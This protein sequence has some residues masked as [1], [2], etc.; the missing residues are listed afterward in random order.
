MVSLPK[1]LCGG[2]S[3]PL[4]RL[5]TEHPGTL[6]LHPGFLESRVSIG[7]AGVPNEGE[8][9]ERAGAAQGA[10]ASKRTS[11]R[12][13][14][15]GRSW[16]PNTLPSPPA[17]RSQVQGTPRKNHRLGPQR[18]KDREKDILSLVRG[19]AGQERRR[20]APTPRKGLRCAPSEGGPLLDQ[21]LGSFQPPTWKGIRE[22]PAPTSPNQIIDF[23]F[24]P[25]CCLES[26]PDRAGR[27]LGAQSLI[28][29]VLRVPSPCRNLR[30]G[31]GD[32]TQ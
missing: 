29:A 8:C 23:K 32:I 21:S 10:A 6:A 24:L 9:W 16:G 30:R 4:L 15:S 20:N 2:R 27:P 12:C 13:P 3:C 7:S 31:G 14:D 5:P 25:S 17:L 19:G 22:N 11:D 28:P 18:W 1:P 26:F